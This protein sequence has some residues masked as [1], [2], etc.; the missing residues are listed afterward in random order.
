M[1]IDCSIRGYIVIYKIFSKSQKDSNAEFIIEESGFYISAFGNA[2][3]RFKAYYIAYADSEL[4]Y[5]FFGIY[6]F[7]KY[8]FTGFPC[9]FDVVILSIYMD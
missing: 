4:F 1:S 2:N 7:I 9:T 5:V 3:V 8:Y 6:V